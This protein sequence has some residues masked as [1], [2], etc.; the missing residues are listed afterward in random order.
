MITIVTAKNGEAFDVSTNF[1]GETVAFRISD[2]AQVDFGRD[3]RHSRIVEFM[4][5]EFEGF[6]IGAQSRPYV[7]VYIPFDD[8]EDN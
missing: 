6:E 7:M 8:G 5:T 2:G 1:Q 3:D 4:M